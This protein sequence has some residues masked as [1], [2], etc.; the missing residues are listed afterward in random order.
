MKKDA[1]EGKWKQLQGH[2]KEWWGKLT[3]DD[4]KRVGGQFNQFVGVLQVECAYTREYAEEK[5]DRR[6]TEHEAHRQEVATPAG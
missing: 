5:I 2:A 3:D 1:F 6:M 4:L